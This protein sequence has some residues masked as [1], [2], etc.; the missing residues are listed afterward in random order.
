[1]NLKLFS[2]FV[3]FLAST[4]SSYIVDK[5]NCFYSN[6]Y[7]NYKQLKKYTCEI[8]PDYSN[9][10]VGTIGGYHIKGKYD[11]DVQVVS[12]SY[13]IK[14][15][16]F[17]TFSTTF[18]DKFNNLDNI[19]FVDANIRYLDPSGFKN[20]KKLETLNLDYNEIREIPEDLLV[21]NRKLWS[22]YISSNKLTKL[23]ENT[24]RSQQELRRLDLSRNY[25]KYLPRNIFKPLKKLDCLSLGRNH[26]ATL[27]HAWFMSLENLKTLHLYSNGITDL[28]QNIFNSLNN[29]WIL[30]LESNKLSKIRRNS[31][32]MLKNLEHVYLNDNKINAIDRSFIEGLNATKE[33][34]M[35]D[36]LC[37][38][39]R[40]YSM[41]SMGLK[42]KLY[43]C[44]QNCR[45]LDEN[46]RRTPTRTRFF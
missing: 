7:N 38:N 13:G 12:H 16:T 37:S 32:G 10:Y 40:I 29:L 43:K 17:G 25:I 30:A 15:I 19:T 1:M 22:F 2:I 18:C 44:M 39:D 24:F 23:H 27:D 36:N 34:D 35:R 41:S 33:F 31:F 42:N 14:D 3:I 11:G 26:L 8:K 5:S 4:D 45:P 28:P 6:S 46:R 21:K 20:C 9:Y